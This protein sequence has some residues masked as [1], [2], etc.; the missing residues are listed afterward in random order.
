MNASRL[1]F[2][3]FALVL[4]VFGASAFAG[5]APVAP[6]EVLAALFGQ[7]EAATRTIVWEIRLPRAAA[8]FGVGT[9]LGLSGAALQGLLQNPLAEPGVLGV[10]SAASLGAVCV[11][12][13]GFG[14]AGNLIV[15]GAAIGFALLA[16]VLLLAVT[17]LRGGAVQLILTGVGLSSVCGALIA[18]AFN[19][20][21]NPFSLSD[22]VNWM[23]GSVANRSWLDMLE[24]LPVWILGGALVLRAGRGLSALTLGEETALSLGM[25]P[26][27]TQ[28][29]VV[30]GTALLTGAS[31][32]LAGAIGFV[33]IVAPHLVRPWVRHDP[34]AVL[35]PSALV[36]GILLMVADLLIR[37]LAFDPE[38]KLGV[39]ASLFGAPLFIWI[40]ARMRS[41]T[42]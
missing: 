41:V 17:G 34:K 22:L 1:V 13:F 11:I 4:L 33:G 37:S 12:Y 29:L 6:A 18:L 39:A 14:A 38:L 40:A 30:G 36:G 24:V 7:G 20:A 42:P 9:A 19:L 25:D 28:R 31:V 21:P 5:T 2:S 3:L 15:T 35:V 32:A 8:A 23:M 16:V 26:R 10:S 27:A